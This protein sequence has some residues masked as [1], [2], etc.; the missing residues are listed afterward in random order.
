MKALSAR[1]HL[2][3]DL[4]T[5]NILY[6][7]LGRW[8]EASSLQGICPIQSCSPDSNGHK[9]WRPGPWFP[10]VDPKNIG[11]STLG[12]SHASRRQVRHHK[13]LERKV[14]ILKF[15]LT[16]ASSLARCRPVSERTERRSEF[17][18]LVT[19]A[20]PL[21]V[22]QVSHTTIGAVGTGYAGRIGEAALS[23]VGLGNS[24]YFAIMVMGLGLVLGFDPLIAQALGAEE[25]QRARHLCIQAC[26]LSLWVSIPCAMITMGSIY[27]LEFIDIDPDTAELTGRFI[28]ARLPSLWPFLLGI[29]LRTY[30]QAMHLTRSLIVGAILGNLVNVP[31]GYALAFGYAPLHIPAFGVRGIGWSFAVSAIVITLVM[32]A[33]VIRAWPRNETPSYRPQRP[34]M[35][36]ACKVGAPLSVQL[37]AE[38]GVFALVTVVAGIIG[39]RALAAHH[40]ALTLSSL[41]FQITLAIG[42][43]VSV[44]VGHAVGRC[45]AEGVTRAGFIAIGMAAAFMSC[46]ALVFI[47]IPETLGSFLTSDLLVIEAALPLLVVAA[48]FQI[49]DGVQT[50]AAGALRGTG[51]T[52]AP[53]FANL[54]GHYAFGLPLGL[55][56]AFQLG[57]GA[58][59]LWWGLSLGLTLVAFALTLRFR[60]VS[61]RPIVR[62]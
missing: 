15:R 62:L 51:D 38:V 34:P 3:R 39:T 14:L 48:V 28:F 35:L 1:L 53:M 24:I 22:L 33:A 9:P 25:G 4:Q 56:L 60:R 42:T 11:A 47:S 17:R 30:L 46:S 6:A 10:I 41:T 29:A 57:M 58:T 23:A 21:A 19:L 18:M 37:T 45:D 49:G 59:G 13:T 27:A 55:F 32:L 40:V 20:M 12:D 8:I 54:I 36:R 7:A 31:L 43:A 26:W 16:G 5:G 61:S 2:T 44:R 50:V 52:K